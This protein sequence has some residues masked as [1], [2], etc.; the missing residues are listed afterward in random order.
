MPLERFRNNP[1]NEYILTE[2]GNLQSREVAK[3]YIYDK[4]RDKYQKP[5]GAYIVHHIDGETFN[6]SIKNLYI[7]TKEEHDWIHGEQIRK[8]R[9]F[10]NSKQIDIFLINKRAE[11][12][13]KLTFP[14]KREIILQEATLTKERREKLYW[15]TKAKQ[16]KRLVEERKI[17]LQEE[18]RKEEKEKYEKLQEEKRKIE[19]KEEE[20]RKRLFKEEQMR[21]EEKERRDTER[22]K[23][24]KRRIIGGILGIILIILGIILFYPDNKKE[25]NS[26]NNLETIIQSFNG[27]DWY[28]Q[29]DSS[30]IVRD[31]C[32]KVC[33]PW[34]LNS[35][36]ID[37]RVKII[38]CDC[39]AGRWF[40][41]KSNELKEI[42]LEQYQ[43]GVQDYQNNLLIV[44]N[45]GSRIR[46]ANNQDKD[47]SVNVMYRLYSSILG[48][49]ITEVETFKISANSEKTFNP[50]K[51][52]SFGC[53]DEICNLEIKS[54][55]EI[56]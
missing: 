51:Y 36:S 39:G 5:F 34:I 4:D 37:I 32:T 46:I 40:D 52:A 19:R 1:N 41:Y 30:P 42:S 17:S 14:E 33:S 7:C 9:K 3:K 16:E 48:V 20:K 10:E 50:Y 23:K 11:G 24:K 21:R 6:N 53:T 31:F 43:R 54:Y 45:N 47:I 26:E 15:E 18:K 13:K 55:L 49:D 2:E 29:G 44:Q 8:K 25:E 38:D 56:K 28:A 12:N 22:R 35:Y 27:I